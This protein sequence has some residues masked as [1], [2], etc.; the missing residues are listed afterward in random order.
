MEIVRGLCVAFGLKIVNE[1]L[2]FGM[3]FGNDKHR[4]DAKHR[5][6]N[7]VYI[8]CR[9]WSIVLMCINLILSPCSV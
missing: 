4:D 2:E 3:Q 5:D 7:R 9:V 6:H 8:V 1:T